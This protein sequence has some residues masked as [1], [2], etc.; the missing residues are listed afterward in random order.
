[1]ILARVLLENPSA[2]TL[3]MRRW[4]EKNKEYAAI[5]QRDW[6]RK[7]RLQVIDHYGGRCLCCG[8]T[9][10]QFLAL[11][12]KDGGGTKHREETGARG[13]AMIDWILKNN[14]PDLFQILCHNCNQARGFYGICPHE[15]E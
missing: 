4:R 11:D 9:R 2:K 14:F 15:E 8:E 1:M 6:K 13:D 12:H 5:Y 7:R 3:A 10:W